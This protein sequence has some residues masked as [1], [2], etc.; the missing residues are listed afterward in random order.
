MLVPVLP[1]LVAAIG[2]FTRIR[3][4]ALG[5]IFA[6]AASCALSCLALNSALQSPSTHAVYNFDWFAL[7]HGAVRL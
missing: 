4:I 1:L 7:G 6:L 3:S 2:A 5:A